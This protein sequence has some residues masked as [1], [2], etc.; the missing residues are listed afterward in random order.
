MTTKRGCSCEDISTDGSFERLLTTL[1]SDCLVVDHYDIDISWEQTFRPFVRRL[2]VIDDQD[3]RSHDCDIYV[4]P[5]YE[6]LDVHDLL[7]PTCQT[8][9]GKN[10]LFFATV[11][12]KLRPSNPGRKGSLN[13]VLI[14]LGGSDVTGLTSLIVNVFAEVHGAALSLSVVAGPTNP[15]A[16]TIREVCRT[17]ENYT[18]YE[19]V[20]SLGP[21]LAQS[22]LA[23]IS[24]G[25]TM[26][27]A[28]YLAT[29]S[30]SEIH[31]LRLRPRTLAAPNAFLNSAGKVPF[32]QPSCPS[33]QKSTRE[34]AESASYDLPT[35]LLHCLSRMILLTG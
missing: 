31:R 15:D 35:S 29:P 33:L 5:D 17:Q 27:E 3:T 8:F 18:F 21:L 32:L 23:V 6:D 10:Y 1:Q 34:S 11:F 24:G 25:M 4:N 14:S 7:P 19:T 20:P 9:M 13:N 30:F 28:C 22:D 26:W 16:N 12:L 2:L